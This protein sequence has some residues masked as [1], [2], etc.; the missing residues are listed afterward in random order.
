MGLVYRENSNR[1]LIFVYVKQKRSNKGVMQFIF[2]FKS[3]FYF[4]TKSSVNA[5][6]Y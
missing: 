4:E 5:L 2:H 3:K 6:F 1:A